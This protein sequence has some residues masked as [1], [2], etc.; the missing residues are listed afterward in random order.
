MIL[1]LLITAKNYFVFSLEIFA[2]SIHTKQISLKCLNSFKLFSN[3]P[4]IVSFR[5]PLIRFLYV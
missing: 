4:A 5:L 3:Y 2:E 1:V